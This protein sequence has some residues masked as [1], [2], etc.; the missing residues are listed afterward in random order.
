MLPLL[1]D[2]DGNVGSNFSRDRIRGKTKIRSGWHIYIHAS[3]HRF[4]IPVPMFARIT[5][6]VYFAG[7]IMG[8]GIKFGALYIN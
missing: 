8:L 2:Y 6:N 7:H 4:K 1:L 5:A 3:G